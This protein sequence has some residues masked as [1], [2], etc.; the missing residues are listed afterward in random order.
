VYGY[1]PAVSSPSALASLTYNDTLFFSTRSPAGYPQ[2]A[3]AA[4][5][6][7]ALAELLPVWQQSS[8]RAGAGLLATPS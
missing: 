6:T 8:S 7:L 1:L 5:P 3:R 4:R 2:A